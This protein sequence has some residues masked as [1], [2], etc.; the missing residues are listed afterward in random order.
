VKAEK[1]EQPKN[2]LSL[3]DIIF[4]LAIIISATLGIVHGSNGFEGFQFLLTFFILTVLIIA[5]YWWLDDFESHVPTRQR[6][7]GF[8]WLCLKVYIFLF[9][10]S[11]IVQSDWFTNFIET[12][13]ERIIGVIEQIMSFIGEILSW[14]FKKLRWLFVF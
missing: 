4:S 1:D 5:Y 11:V 13:S 12:W 2:K 10:V 3:A 9:L 7:F 6:V 8:L 14:I